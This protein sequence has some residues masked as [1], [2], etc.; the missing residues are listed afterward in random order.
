[1]IRKTS[2]G[3]DDEYGFGQAGS[4]E[5]DGLSGLGFIT[6]SGMIWLAT[7]RKATASH[8]RRRTLQ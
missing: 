1:M 3:D 8:T 4:A 2:G 7:D 6:K 5:Q